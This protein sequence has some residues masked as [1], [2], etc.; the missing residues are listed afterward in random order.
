MG[1]HIEN[2]IGLK[3]IL[4]GAGALFALLFA[5]PFVDRNPKRWWRKRPVAIALGLLVLAC[6]V[7]LSIIEA[8][9]TPVSHLG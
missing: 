4:Y 1:V 6:L 5:V 8:V 3:G 2:K 9:A 7:V